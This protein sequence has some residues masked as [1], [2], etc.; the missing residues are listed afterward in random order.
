M[1]FKGGCKGLFSW[2][3]QMRSAWI[4]VS[5]WVFKAE[6]NLNTLKNVSNHCCMFQM[7]IIFAK[8]WLNTQNTCSLVFHINYKLFTARF[9]AYRWSVC[10]IQNNRW[11]IK[12]VKVL[13]LWSLFALSIPTAVFFISLIT[14]VAIF[15]H[16]FY[17]LIPIK[18][19]VAWIS[20]HP[21]MYRDN[22]IQAL[23]TFTHP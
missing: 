23:C 7:V 19:A 16:Y 14:F 13:G 4:H 9:K 11:V 17:T 3:K 5:L 2:R 20:G 15:F 22:L 18:P 6:K 21:H 1:G 10:H 8:L 12:V